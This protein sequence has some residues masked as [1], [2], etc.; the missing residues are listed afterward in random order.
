M[1]TCLACSSGDVTRWA[2]ARDV[3]Y[4]S[5]PERFAYYRCRACDALSIDPVPV[6]RLAEIYPAG[7]YSFH[8]S[9][10]GAVHRVKNWLDRRW[11]KRVAAGI[12]GG[13]LAAL[14]IG[15]GSGQQSSTLRAAVP[16]I[17]RTVIVDLDER[18]ESVARG[19]GHEYVR[20][21]IEDAPI[22]GA[23]D[24]ILL[25]NLI[26]HVRDPLAVLQKTRSLLSPG[27]RLIVKT[28]NYRSLDARLFRHRNWGG[29]HCPRHWVIFTRESFERLAARA[30]LR[31]V[32]ASYTQGAPFW[33]ISAL[34][35]LEERGVVAI[36]RERPVWRHPLYGPLMG[37]FAAVDFVR[38]PVAPLS[39][40]TFSLERC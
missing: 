32:A 35:W 23:F 24:V 8:P 27:G 20:G 11:F 4:Q 38:G 12:P 18:A 28:P 7:Y 14:D 17:S 16:R 37:L 1:V 29:Y 40:M 36:S 31:V 34:A 15:G 33:T 26:E 9:S 5:V 3:E 30:G 13:S 19:L 10:D 22:D 6:D 25:L 39:Q 2:D 21:R